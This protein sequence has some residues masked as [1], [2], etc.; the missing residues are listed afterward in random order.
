MS[1]FAIAPASE[2]FSQVIESVVFDE[3]TLQRRVQEI[4]AQVS[5][6]YRGRELIVIGI[7]KGAHIFTCDL[8]RYITIPVVMDFVSISRYKRA[9]GYKEVA[10]TH[11]LE[12]D[13]KGKDILLVED[14]IDTGLTLHYLAGILKQREPK[15]IAICSLLDRPALRLADIPMKYVGF[16]VDEEQFLIGY[17]LDYREQYRELPFI[18]EMHI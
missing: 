2:S 9:P 6:D 8:I 3:S 5:F 4:A 14:I 18:A 10:I 12:A 15:S 11:D 13:I 1:Q 17:G 16:N 7:L